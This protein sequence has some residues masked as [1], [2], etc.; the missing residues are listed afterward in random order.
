[1]ETSLKGRP[2]WGVHPAFYLTP[3]Y[4]AHLA[5]RILPKPSVVDYTLST[6]DRR[7]G[8]GF[9]DPPTEPCAA[10]PTALAILTLR[11]FP[12]APAVGRAIDRGIQW[13]LGTQRRNGAFPRGRA[14]EELFYVGDVYP[15]CLSL[16]ALSG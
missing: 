5:A 11:A 13:L 8:W 7:G 9:G 4:P 14:P 10:L 1:L 3:F 16:F 6:Q 2:I 15:T 12:R